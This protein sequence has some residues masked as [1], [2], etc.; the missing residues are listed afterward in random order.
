MTRLRL[1]GLV[2]AVL[3]LAPLG[4]AA[5]DQDDALRLAQRIAS[6]N[7]FAE[8]TVT[9]HAA[10]K[11]LPTSVPL[12]KA[13]LLGSVVE[14]VRQ[15]MFTMS[16]GGTA[17]TTTSVAAAPPMLLYY[18]APAGRDATVSAY[19]AALMQAGWKPAPDFRRRFPIPQGGFTLPFPTIKLWCSAAEP[20]T[21]ISITNADDASGFDLSIA[22]SSRGTAF[23]C[24]DAPSPFDDFQRRS[25]LPT[26]TAPS[27][28]TITASGP[29][30]DGSTTGAR[31]E[32]KLGLAA[33]FDAFAKQLADAGWAAASASIGTPATRTQTFK[34]TVDGTSFVALFA[35]YA[36][37]ATHY[38]ALADVS[39]VK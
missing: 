28:I 11:N 29:A 10:P 15:G 14:T 9:L 32:S 6:R 5:S 21:A 4:A 3:A 27:G 18:D 8:A 1:A 35:L 26:F 22:S 20:R 17:T 13:T 2:A 25:P 37:D 38:V 39:D 7:G 23:Q 34:K 33:V 19:E 24:S 31:I 30:S 12:P 36:L 16:S